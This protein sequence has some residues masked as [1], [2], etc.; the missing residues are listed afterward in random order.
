MVVALR[1]ARVQ[2]AH[3]RRERDL[4]RL[5]IR[6][7][8]HPLHLRRPVHVQAH[9]APPVHGAGK[10][11]CCA[12][13]PHRELRN[14]DSVGSHR[15]PVDHRGFHQ[16]RAA[17]S[18]DRNCDARESELGRVEMRAVLEKIKHN[19]ICFK[20]KTFNSTNDAKTD[21]R[22]SIS[23]QIHTEEEEEASQTDESEGSE[24]EEEE[25]DESEE[26]EEEED[27]EDAAISESSYESTDSHYGF[28]Y[29]EGHI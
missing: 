2:R 9:R 20:N 25:E 6:A 13:V 5:S 11:A 21:R 23:Q 28:F 8:E 22:P 12:R 29:P 10:G 24:D 1:L 4:E 27:E 19:K 26:S 16:R 14:A 15:P 17:L 3:G 18:D 7:R